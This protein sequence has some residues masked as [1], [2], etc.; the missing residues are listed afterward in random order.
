M[1]THPEIEIARRKVLELYQ[2]TYDYLR[3][4]PTTFLEDLLH[5]AE[6]LH[7]SSSFSEQAAA[8]INH[9]ACVVILEKRRGT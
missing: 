9:A 4:K 7:H 8:K 5:R 1:T 6:E 3:S 2:A